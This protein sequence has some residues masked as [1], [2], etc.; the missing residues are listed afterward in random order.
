MNKKRIGSIAAIAVVGVL[1]LSSCAA[2]ESSTPAAS[3]TSGSGSSS[4]P[5]SGT[6]NGIGSSAQGV[7]ET[8][9]AAGFQTANP[10]ATVNYDPQGSGAGRTSFASG[11]ANF[12]GSDAALATA[13]LS[14]SFAACATGTKGIDIPVYISPISL[15]YNISGVKDLTLD[16]STIAGIFSGSIKTWNDPAIKALNSGVSLPSAAITVVHRS[17]DSGTTENFTEYLAS[18]APK[19]WTKPASQTFPY[20]V[21]DAAKGTSG[22]ASAV[23]NSTNSIAYIDKSGAGSL[24]L[25]KVK[26]GDK[27]TTISAT[28]AA[29]VVTK[30]PLVSGRTKNDIAVNIDR[31]LTAKGDWPIVLVSYLITCQTYKSSTVGK[32]VKAY[33]EYVTSPAAQKAAAAQ[34]GSAPL[35]GTLSTDA[36]K[37]AASIK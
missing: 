37:A 22:V 2:N 21:G 33:A 16:A 30:S 36:Q 20:T 23:Q 27:A 32:E 17:D 13:D 14:G 6:I 9:W 18:Q 24:S 34:A 1:A 25:A 10:N 15:A 35:S 11:A 26:F 7:A 28:G 5:V 3:A 8:T 19:V 29:A 4:A 31:S 12:A